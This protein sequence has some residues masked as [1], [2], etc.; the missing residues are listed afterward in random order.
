MKKAVFSISFAF[1]CFLI[2]AQAPESFSYQAIV[3]NTAGEPIATQ[4]VIFLFSI[5][6]TTADGTVVY[7]EKHAV[8]TNEFGL[9]NLAIGNGTDKVGDF[10]T[11]D[12]GTDNYFLK[13]EL[14]KGDA[15]FVDM[16]TIQ[17]LSVPFA[18]H[19]KTSAD[20]DGLKADI[21]ELKLFT[22]KKLKDIDGN[23][24]TSVLIGTQIWMAENLKTTKYNDGT[25]I[26]LITDPAEWSGLVTPG[27]CWYKNDETT[28][29]DPYGA[30]YNWYTLNTGK[31]CPT[32][33]H[34]ASN[35]EFTALVTFLGGNLVAGGKLKETG[36]IHWNSPNTGATNETGFTGVAAGFRNPAGSFIAFGAMNYFWSATDN[37]GFPYCL[38]LYFDVTNAYQDTSDKPYGLSVRCV[39]D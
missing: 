31:L 37:G 18:L 9:V 33:W 16:G 10:T 5:I 8:K 22:G 27:Y 17:L 1:I 4:D 11:I 7:T 32:G 39:K 38:F 29:K 12:W 15:I 20:T 25:E 2:S 24:Y 28:Y 19:S 13:V 26:P 6:K 21:E 14:D 36:I 3:R 34:A 35:D 23:I 30:L